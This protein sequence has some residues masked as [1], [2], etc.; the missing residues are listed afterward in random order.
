MKAILQKVPVSTD[1]SFAVQVFCSPYFD[2]PW[3]FHP[4]Y[5]LVLVLQGDGTRFVGDSIADFAPGD[6]VLLGTN[7]PHWYRNSAAY[8]TNDPALQ[9]KS[10]VI[11][12]NREFLGPAF[13]HLPETAAIRKLLDKA[14]QGISINGNTRTLLADKMQ[15]MVHS[16][17]MDR[18]LQLLS[19]LHIAA[20]ATDSH[21]LSSRGASGINVKDAERMNRI[22]EFVMQHFTDPISTNEVSQ[23]VNM[24]PSAFCRYFKKR[25]RKHFTYFL[26]ELRIG[27]A[28]KLL[29]EDDLSI[30]EIC[31]MSG[32]NNISYFNRQ[33]KTFKKKTPQA[34]KQ[35]F[36]PAQRYA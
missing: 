19:M 22:Y 20:G 15:Q 32:Y 13:F 3:H 7:L 31:F 6:L 26:N 29:Q 18:L 36:A 14:V 10:I 25:T 11:Q 28:C 21:L 35:E 12:F 34:F 23:A 1:A 33:F 24:S 17:G 16:T 9:A 4:E 5:E 2:T 8:Y 30:T 27:H